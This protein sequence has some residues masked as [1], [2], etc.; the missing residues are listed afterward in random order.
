MD[1]F[2]KRIDVSKLIKATNEA[3]EEH[4]KLLSKIDSKEG[5]PTEE[6]VSVA[7]IGSAGRN[8]EIQMVTKERY[9]AM[10]LEAENII[11]EQWGLDWNHVHL[12]SGGAA[13]ADHVAVDLYLKHKPTSEIKLTL[14]LPC[15]FHHGQYFSIEGD[16]NWKTNPGGISNFYHRRFSKKIGNDEDYSLSQIQTAFDTG[17]VLHFSK[18]FFDRNCKVAKSEKMIAYTFNKTAPKTGGTGHTWNHSKLPSKDKKHVC[19]LDL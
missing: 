11:V 5:N 19:I 7:I 9:E 8:D 16:R 10:I 14:E 2:V 18:G 3:V 6:Y 4:K 1:D 12:F 15:K 13:N 17:A